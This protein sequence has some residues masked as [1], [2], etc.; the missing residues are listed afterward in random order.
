MI[1][2]SCP[3]I[4]NILGIDNRNLWSI[5]QRIAKICLGLFSPLILKCALTRPD[6]AHCFNSAWVKF[7]ISQ[8]IDTTG[9]PGN[10][11]NITGNIGVSYGNIA[12][13]QCYG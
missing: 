13:G 8:I 9:V 7:V 2:K 6:V 12:A 10:L 11:P 4:K 3:V 1:P 5:T